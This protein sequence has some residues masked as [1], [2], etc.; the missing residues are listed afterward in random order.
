MLSSGIGVSVTSVVEVMYTVR[1]YCRI[2]LERL[3]MLGGQMGAFERWTAFEY[4]E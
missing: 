2:K 1:L 4:I 3:R